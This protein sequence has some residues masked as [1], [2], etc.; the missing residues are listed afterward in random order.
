MSG[1]IAV[2][3]TDK[4]KVNKEVL[5]ALT[6]S[7]HSR[8]PDRQDTFIDGS[9]GL[10][11]TLFRT[12]FEAA[13]DTQPASIDGKV[14]ITSS[15]RIDDR[16]NL[17][18]KLGLSEKLTLEH[19]PDYELILLAYRKWGEKCSKSIMESGEMGG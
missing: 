15:A 7:L 10:G 19:T 4:T 16:V 13:F 9:I 1:I 6:E 11:H 5:S 8:G 17:V 2:Y 14:W 3:Q 18:E 12:T